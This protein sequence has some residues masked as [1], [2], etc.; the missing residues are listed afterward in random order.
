[1]LASVRYLFGECELDTETFE[2]RRLG[3][4]AGLPRRLFDVLH[5]LIER[6]GQ[7]VRKFELMEACWPDSEVTEASLSHAIMELRRALGDRIESPVYIETVRGRGFRLLTE[8]RVAEE[9]SATSTPRSEASLPSML[10]IPAGTV[11]VRFVG[12]DRVLS[13]LEALL[14]ETAQ[15]NGGSAL[16][17]GEH[18]IGKTRVLAELGARTQGRTGWLVGLRSHDRER[19]ALWPWARL[20]ASLVER[21]APSPQ[22]LPQ[23]LL[24]ALPRPNPTAPLWGSLE[25]RG[26]FAAKEALA[27]WLSQI[28]RERP[29]VILWDDVHLADDASLALL[30]HLGKHFQEIPTALVCSYNSAEARRRSTLA[31]AL[32]TLARLAPHRSAMLRGLGRAEVSELLASVLGAPVGDAQLDSLLRKTGGNPQFLLSSTAASRSR[33]GPASIPASSLAANSGVAEVVAKHI[34]LLPSGVL[35]LLQISSVLGD[36]F[37][38]RTLAQVSQ[39][40][41]SLALDLLSEACQAGIVLETPG[42]LGWYTFEHPLVRGVLY[43]R[44]APEDRAALHDAAANALEEQFGSKHPLLWPSLAHHLLRSADPDRR[45]RGAVVALD[46][47]RAA[48]GRGDASAAV[49]LCRRALQAP[50]FTA[51]REQ[52]CA[53]LAEAYEQAGAPEEARQVREQPPRA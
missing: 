28:T 1:M 6:P 40:E 13:M 9:V 22:E 4:A 32:G 44:W 23:E 29:L 35:G 46:A 48:L 27:A 34:D 8:V 37:S 26:Q 41:E 42:A 33:L 5:Y 3:G 7:V 45:K 50:V 10:R 49:L 36:S 18:G 30:E 43:R 2:L 24:A 15:G 14:D 51:L 12:R 53:A 11:E 52:I 31:S 21:G 47:A 19:A 38:L 25:K 20:I 17:G 16:L 39:Q